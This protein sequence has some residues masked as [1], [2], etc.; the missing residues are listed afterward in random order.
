MAHI[1]TADVL[2]DTTLRGTGPDEHPT[3]VDAFPSVAMAPGAATP[4]TGSA[5]PT[6][7]RGKRPKRVFPFGTRPG[8]LVTYV[9]GVLAAWGLAAATLPDG[10]PPAL[11]LV[12]ATF[13][14]LTSLVAVGLVV[15]YR[16]NR[17][18]NF[19]QASM[20]AAA[21]TLTVSLVTD[22]TIPFPVAVCAGVLAGCIAG[23]L[24]E[25]VVIRRFFRRARLTMTVATIG[26]AQL[27]AAAAL[28]VPVLF[29]GAGSVYETPLSS[30][31]AEFSGVILTGDHLVV[32]VAVAAVASALGVF[33]RF[34]SL[35]AALRAASDNPD[36]A[37]L[38]GLPVRSLSTIG[39]TIAGACAA[40]GAILAAPITGTDAA[41]LGG[42][43][44]LL[45]GLVAATVAR[46]ENIP[47]AL[48]TALGIGVVEQVVF[49]NYPDS[50]WL[51][52][53]L[54][55]VVLVVL[56]TRHADLWGARTDDE[57][58]PLVD[59]TK[60]LPRNITATAE[61]RLLRVTGWLIVAATVA[62]VPL[63]L[64]PAS[65][66]M[67]AIIVINVVV[68]AS[69]VL[70]TGWA[71]QVSLGQYAIAGIGGGVTAACVGGLGID[72][73]VS[74][75]AGAA[76]GACAA[77]LIGLPAL[78]IR[79]Q[80]LAVTTLALSVPVS[81]VL[82]NPLYVPAL[83]RSEVTRPIL[84]G[85]FDLEDGR[86]FFWFCVAAAAFA[87]LACHNFRRS[88]AGRV[89]LASRDNPRAAAAYG[90]SPVKAKLMA[91][92]LS[93]V[94]AG[95]AGGLLIIALR[96]VPFGY[97]GAD[98]G[99]EAFAMA[100]I[101]GV[102]S[103]LGAVLG[104]LTIGLID[105]LLDGSVALFATGILLLAIIYARPD[106]LAGLVLS[107]RKRLVALLPQP[108]PD[109]GPPPLPEIPVWHPQDAPVSNPASNGT[110]P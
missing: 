92:G 43:S 86:Y 56:L 84:F 33:L 110:M 77:L 103:L 34:T 83:A 29:K 54:V 79:G 53:A 6:E 37:L 104:A 78:R 96:G 68:A 13:G 102:V 82:L 51:D 63:A 30:W 85:R 49:W 107:L 20:G 45:G 11:L 71:G 36:R 28:A 16:A 99:L 76:A 48:V 21:G 69:L 81:T 65:L 97:F 70:L 47:V 101:G 50:G 4:G 106:G 108:R 89:V 75:I 109:T 58:V 90:V 42:P 74:L 5:V 24:V 14:G 3:Y 27:F 60:P 19:A 22:T 66:D 62:V 31:A 95:T 25:L 55:I 59:V 93:G 8:R 44:L 105:N 41:A 98:A 17:V 46:F 2:M 94:M 23:G 52:V 7:P 67:A 35:G 61:Y 88:R 91:F 64:S 10:A 73:L 1:R 87:L 9:G 32:L 15:V 12:G 18:V 100:V 72:L 57:S 38:A 80:Y 40:L 26:V 39:W